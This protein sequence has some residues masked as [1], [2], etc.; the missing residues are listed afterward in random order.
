MTESTLLQRQDVPP[1]SRWNDTAVFPSWDEWLAEA[2][3]V[4]AE[5][6]HLPAFENTLTRGPAELADWLDYYNGLDRRLARLS[7]Y[8]GMATAVDAADAP[9]KERRGQQMGL[10]AQFKARSAFAEPAMMALGDTLLDWAKEEPRLAIYEHYFANLL[11]Q[12]A[13]RRS[14]EVEEVLGMVMEPFDQV[15]Q[16][17]DDLTALELAFADARDSA[18]AAHPVQQAIVPPSDIQNP[19]RELRRTAWESYCDGFLALQNTLASNYIA[20]VKQYVFWA[21][22]RGYG[23][24][25]E[26][27]L[28][29]YN[30]PVEVFHTLI[31]TFEA[32]LPVW[33]R[34]WAVKRKVLGVDELHPYD[35]WAPLVANPPVVPYHAAVD[36]ICEGLAPLGEEYTAVMRRG[37]LEEGWVDYAPNVGKAQGAASNLSY[38][39]P[40]FIYTSYNDTLMSMSVLAHELGHSMHSHL[41]DSTS[42]TSTTT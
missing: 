42:R 10:Y 3:A 39:M 17:F 25:L 9:A 41:I 1:Q 23:S 8:A 36:R 38:D 34:Y 2:E 19:D 31:E 20:A 28:A 11:R 21:R 37:C 4:K 6:A 16:T 5:L 18:G 13:H 40:P 14:A 26:A 35:I 33:H 27:Q 7:V 22:V 12:K 30:V 29:P 32:N 15:G 24:V